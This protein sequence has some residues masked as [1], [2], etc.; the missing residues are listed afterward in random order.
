MSLLSTCNTT[1][2][3]K[4][5]I[6][7]VGES[8]SSDEETQ[9]FLLP[10][11]PQ[12]DSSSEPQ[13]DSSSVSIHRVVDPPKK[14]K[15][16]EETNHHHP[17]QNTPSRKRLLLLVVIVVGGYIGSFLLG[18]FYKS[19]TTLMPDTPTTSMTTTKEVGV[20]HKDSSS[21]SSSSSSSLSSIVQKQ[22]VEEEE[23]EEEK[24][25]TTTISMTTNTAKE[26]KEVGGKTAAA[27]SSSSS[28]SLVAE[29]QKQNFRDGTGLLLNLHITHHGGTSFCAT[30]RQSLTVP[31]RF[32]NHAS[33][34][35]FQLLEDE[36]EDED[37]DD[38]AAAAARRRKAQFE[39]INFNQKGGTKRPWSTNATSRNIEIVRQSFQM[40]AWEAGKTPHPPLSTTHWEDPHLVSVIIMRDPISRAISKAGKPIRRHFEKTTAT[41]TLSH[42]EWSWWLHSEA[43]N[44][45]ALNKLSD[46]D[47]SS[48]SSS[49]GGCCSRQDTSRDHLEAAKA[50]LRRFTYV[51][52]LRCLEAGMESIAKELGFWEDF[53]PQYGNR[54]H[55]QAKYQNSTWSP[56]PSVRDQIGYDDLYEFLVTSNPLDSELYEWS[57]SIAHVQCDDE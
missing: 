57:K 41:T 28:S 49:G 29:R 37:D 40:I 24:P 11:E 1:L 43:A 9:S 31:D 16:D 10:A 4:G 54:G 44:N 34:G 7:W 36:D 15:N 22:N 33:N 46:I 25:T 5:I 6:P 47:S 30:M 2:P 21:S 14:K 26:E 50:L 53:H 55:K 17:H 42:D 39:R 35:Q 19:K 56:S 32:C 38:S 18:V 13:D 23:E 27:S 48:S 45:F 52:D 51:L 20:G 3:R 8:S 12:D